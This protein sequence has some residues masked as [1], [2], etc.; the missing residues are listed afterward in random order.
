VA[1][2]TT[3]APGRSGLLGAGIDAVLGSYQ[4][5]QRSTGDYWAGAV[6]RQATPFDVGLDLLSWWTTAV[7]R[8]PPQW[9]TKH[10]VVARWPIARLRDF[11]A[12]TTVET[13][14]TLLLPPQ[15]GHDSCIVDYDAHQSQVATAQQ[16]GLTRLFSLDWAGATDATKNA[17]IEDYIAVIA[18]TVERL[19]GHVNLVGDC[20]GG[21]LAAIYAALHPDQI[22]TLTIAGAPIDFHAGEPLIHDWVRALSPSGD[23]GFYRDIVD[24]NG[25]VL[26]GE[27]LLA[28]FIALRPEKEI[29]RQLQLLAHLHD[30]AH[31][32]RYRRFDAWFQHTQPIPGAFYL[33]IVEHLFSNNELVA[34]SLRV[35]GTVVDLSRIDAPLY[36]LAGATDHITPPAQVFALA[37]HASSLESDIVKRQTAGGHL[38][39]FMGHDALHQQWL[40]LFREIGAQSQ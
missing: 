4:A 15:A 23:L 2:V 26:P 36:L 5:C 9:A 34:G 39:L 10:K 31:V 30:P 19:G 38:G 40:P 6:A 22:N 24:A 20:Q 28:G 12:A 13:I 21:W 1:R 14:P 11:S 17:S 3:L 35:D 8:E 25:G 29:E 16:A 27:F 37:D 18:D 7:R 33:W 32:A